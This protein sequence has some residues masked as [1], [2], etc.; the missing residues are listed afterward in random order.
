[1]A[2]KRVDLRQGRIGDDFLKPGFTHAKKTKRSF[3][4]D[5]TD[6]LK[7]D[8]VGSNLFAAEVSAGWWRDK[9]VH[10]AGRKSTFRGV[11]KLTY[12]DGTTELVGTKA[13]EGTVL[14][15]LPAEM[16]NDSNG[17]RSRGNDGPADSVYRENLRCPQIG[18]RAVY[19]F[20]KGGKTSYMPHGG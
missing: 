7:T 14:T 8:K 12:E 4:Y 19:T 15:C 5:V 20:G 18:M 6:L 13:A 11:V 17:E 1:M 9:I 16:L 2:V 3:T 10:F